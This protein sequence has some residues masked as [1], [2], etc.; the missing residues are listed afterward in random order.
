MLK[1]LESYISI[2]ELFAME[3]KTLSYPI[4]VMH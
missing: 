2:F 1:N 3:N 4:F